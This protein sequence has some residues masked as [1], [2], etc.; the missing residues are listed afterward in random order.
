MW[1]VIQA[2]SAP[3]ELLKNSVIN[4]QNFYGIFSKQVFRSPMAPM[5]TK[6]T[7]HPIW[8][9]KSICSP[10]VLPMEIF[11]RFRKKI[12]GNNRYNQ[13]YISQR[14]CLYELVCHGYRFK[15][16][17]N[18]QKAANNTNT[19]SP[20]GRRCSCGPVAAAIRIKDWELLYEDLHHHTESCIRHTRLR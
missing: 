13:W 3:I 20:F 8:M 1:S 7:R 18:M 2:C 17:E 15:S 11:L 9:L 16:S 19:S 10:Q 4:T 6:T 14:Q 5:P 12:S